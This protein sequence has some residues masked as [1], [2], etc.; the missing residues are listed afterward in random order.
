MALLS[1]NRDSPQTQRVLTLLDELVSGETTRVAAIDGEFYWRCCRLDFV[2]AIEPL[3]DQY[4]QDCMKFQKECDQVVRYLQVAAGST[5]PPLN[6]HHSPSTAGGWWEGNTPT[7]IAAELF[8]DY[9][10]V[11]QVMGAD[12]ASPMTKEMSIAEK[13][14]TMALRSFTDLL[15]QTQQFFDFEPNE[16]DDA[17]DDT[18]PLSPFGEKVLTIARTFTLTY[19]SVLL[20]ITLGAPI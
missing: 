20:H 7:K 12:K 9:Q 8:I 6:S 2:A 1:S 13:A 10:R 14:F 15:R 18:T 5:A 19:S 16:L 3:R 4:R 17:N 11:R